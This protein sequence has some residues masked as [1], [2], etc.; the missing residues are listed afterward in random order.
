V[1]YLVD[2]V[3]NSGVF[4]VSGLDVAFKKVQRQDAAIGCIPA[5]GFIVK[6]IG[7]YRCS[8]DR[9]SA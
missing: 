6:S 3:L 7:A 5:D 2:E 1:V 8:V 9:S 4:G